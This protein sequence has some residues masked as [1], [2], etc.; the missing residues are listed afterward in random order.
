MMEHGGNIYKY[1]KELDLLPTEICDF[2]SNINCYHPPMD[3]TV[4]Q[5][6]VLPYADPNYTSLKATIAKNYA[7]QP[8]NIALFN[9]ATAAIYALFSQLKQKRVFLYA[10]LYKEY[11][12]A[13]LATHKDI[14]KINRIEELDAEVDKK[15]IVVFV[16]PATPEGS[17][18]D[19]EDLFLEWKQKKCT[20]IVDE[21]FL[22]FEGNKS[23]RRQIFDYKKLYIVHSF[24]KFYGCAGVRIGALFSHKK[25]IAT[26][27]HPLWNIS[28]IDAAFLEQRL[29]DPDFTAAAQQ[30]HTTQK[31]QLQTILK[32]SKLFDTIVAS[33]ANFILAHTPHATALFEHLLA[34]KILVRT[35]GSF[36]FLDDSWF[37]FAVKN[38]ADQQHLQKSLEAF[39]TTHEKTSRT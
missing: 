12:K 17:F 34:H 18:Y 33:D 13:A 29:C 4:T 21:S 9:G 15:S 38:E 27:H 36:D 39:A 2:S 31:A 35:C 10:P 22:E 3:F 11:E 37:R 32:E 28:S 8:E 5:Q 24:T 6:M 26:L 19:L 25:N 1:A 23:I 16:N 30:M 7:I 20:I 14:Y